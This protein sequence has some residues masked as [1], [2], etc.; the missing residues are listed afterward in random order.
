MAI[1]TLYKWDDAGAPQLTRQAQSLLTILRKC[2]VEGY[3]SKAALG[4]SIA[5]DDAVNLRTVYRNASGKGELRVGPLSTATGDHVAFLAATSFADITTAIAPGLGDVYLT[6]GASDFTRWFVVGTADAFYLAVW[7]AS[8]T[9]ANT[10]TTARCATYFAGNMVSP[11]G[12]DPHQFFAT[13]RRT[14]Q[15]DNAVPNTAWNEISLLS[16]IAP[17]QSS[18]AASALPHRTVISGGLGGA[19]ERRFVN[20]IFTIDTAMPSSV[21]NLY[22]LT[23]PALA[24]MSPIVLFEL[25][26]AAAVPANKTEKPLVRGMLPGLALIG[27]AVDGVIGQVFT[28]SDLSFLCIQNTYSVGVCAVIALSEWPA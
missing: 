2:L 12:D 20:A 17:S 28:A 13:G 22:P 27:F 3:G 19:A 16:S 26:T 18:P 10:L 23:H 7:D 5:F 24:V 11:A 25:G 8:I 4:W 15:F 1:P 21:S 6:R 14:P 9:S